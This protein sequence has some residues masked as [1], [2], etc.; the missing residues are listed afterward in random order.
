MIEFENVT[1]YYP[2]NSGK[3]YVFRN[4]SFN[5]PERTNIGVLGLNGSGKSTLLRLIGGADYPSEGSIIVNGSVSWPLGLSG[6]TQGSMTG[7]QNAKFV[8][9]VY[10]D[11]DQ[12]IKD[13]LSYIEDFSELGDYFDLPVK[14]YSSGMRSRLIFGI[15]MAF[16]FDIYLIDEITSVGDM[17]FREKSQKALLEKSNKSNYIMVS[18]NINNLIKHCDNLLV[19]EKDYLKLFDN[20]Q[21]GIDY[22]KKSF[23]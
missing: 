11:D 15:S 23:L 13:K 20:I 22:Y 12:I 4:I 3:K 16:D 18:H 10:G 8:S 19:I 6:G 14:S 2:T 5:F 7:R 17:R 9:Q 1:K 21:Q